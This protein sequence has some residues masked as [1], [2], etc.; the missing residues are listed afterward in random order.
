MRRHFT[1]LAATIAALA[2]APACAHAADPFTK[3]TLTF[4]V[5][6]GPKSDTPCKIAADLYKPNGASAANPAAAVMATNGFGGSKADFT[7]LG[8]AYARR[9]YVY[10]A[11]SGLGFGGSGCKIELDDPDWDGRAGSQL[12]SFLG[13]TKAA[14]DG[15][16]A[17]YVMLDG[18]GDPRVGMIGG[19]YGGQI[20]FAVAGLDRRLDAIVPQITWNDLSYSLTPNNTDFAKGVT[21]ATPGVSKLDWPVLFFGLG[22]G[23]GFE[24][25]FTD[26]DPSHLS[27]TCPNFDDR[28]CASLVQSGSTGYPDA[29]TLDLL[30]HASVASYM[31]KIRIPTFLAQGQSDTLFDLQEVVATYQ[32]LRA[33]GTPVKMLWRSSGHSGG[34]LGAQESSSTALEGSYESRMELE[35]FDY[36]L[37]G[38]GDPPTL[39]V[40]FLRDWALPKSGDAAAAVGSTASYRVGGDE[41]LSLSGSDALVA[42]RGAVKAGT[43]SM[44]AAP[45]APASTGGGFTDLG[46]QDAPGASVAFTTPVLSADTDVAGIPRLTVTLDAPTFAAAQAADPATKLVVFAKLYDVDESGKVTLPRNLVSAS[47]V[48]DVSKPVTI[49]LSG[50]VHRFAKGHSIRLVL[51]TSDAAYHGNDFSGPVSVNVDPAKAGALTLPLL[52]EQAGPD[53]SGPDGTTPFKSPSGARAAQPAG[54]GGPARSGQAATLPARTCASRRSFHIRL[55]KGLRSASVLV[56]GRRAKVA[57][58]KRLRATINLRG[59]PKGTFRVVVTGRTAKGRVLHSARTYHTCVAKK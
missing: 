55:R 14:T 1:L 24:H 6:T 18:P 20:Q 16:K 57:R 26:Q 47:R 19:S 39:D 44:A 56:N 46:A 58:G 29:T 34:G 11:Y 7:D 9:G 41:T 36:Y 10:L 37:R 59:L 54:L 22:V 43:A 50:I 8:A 17:D 30:R 52:G 33:Q 48:G 21:Y 35:W 53:G 40:S 42:T 31:S 12:L 2:I 3:K 25:A 51:T 4:D 45:A 49:E 28:V 15:T 27:G 5:M 23:Q 13:G 38:I 32:A